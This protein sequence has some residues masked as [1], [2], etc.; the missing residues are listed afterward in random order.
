MSTEQTLQKTDAAREEI[1][2]LSDAIDQISPAAPLQAEHSE[3]PDVG[4]ALQTARL[5]RQLS[6]EEVARILKL[7]PRQV[8]ALENG[9]WSALPGPAFVRGFVTNYARFLELDVNRLLAGIAPEALSAQYRLDVPSVGDRVLTESRVSRSRSSSLVMLAVAVLVLALLTF[10][11]LPADFR[12]RLPMLTG[13]AAVLE[14]AA[15]VVG[16]AADEKMLVA[17]GTEPA[18]PPAGS[19]PAGNVPAADTGPAPLSPAATTPAAD[20]PLAPVARPLTD[21]GAG[22]AAGALPPAALVSGT[23][24][25]VTGQSVLHLSFA[26]ASWVEI[27]DA[28]GQILHSHLNEAGSSRDVTGKPPFALIVGNASH[29]SLT[30]NGRAVALEPRS[31]EDVARLTL[32]L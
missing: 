32:G 21:A 5:A 14:P 3:R 24:K 13:K 15:Q 30:M 9:E 22:S 1:P 29:V 11:F 6:I 8:V 20:Q 18:E 4:K 10:F 31:K 28:D 26:R 7:G 2:T 27:R 12:E 23:I 25:P 17:P 16:T 19:V